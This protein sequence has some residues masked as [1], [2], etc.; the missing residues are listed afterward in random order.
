MPN[1]AE[2]NQCTGCTACAATCPTECIVMEADE[3]G[4]RHPVVDTAA[5]AACGLC[6]K[7]C[8]VVSPPAQC[9]NLP[10]AYA[11]Y[12]K[13]ETMRLQSSSGGL[14]TEIARIVLAEGGIVYGA[15]Y[16][17]AFRVVHIPVETES[18]LESLRGAK[19]SQSVLGDAF[20]KIKKTLESGHLVLFSGTPCQV[21]GLKA[22][23]RRDYEKLIT[24]DFICHS[25]PSPIA[26]QEF[27]RFRGRQDASGDMPTAIQLRSKI[28]GW[29]RYRYSNRFVY[30]NG[31]VKNIASGESLYM[32]LFGAN[33]IS[34]ESC[35]NC[36]FKGYSRCSDLTL[37]DFWGIWNI[38]PEMDD[39]KGTSVV[40]C[41][42]ERGRT[43]LDAIT[44]RIVLKQ[45]SLEEVSQENWS[46]LRSA[47]QNPNRQVALEY[48]R[49]G[50]I[51]DC[52]KWLQP[53]KP[54]FKQKLTRII[55]KV[56]RA[57][58]IEIRKIKLSARK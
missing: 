31:T 40:L 50:R 17:E 8:P 58:F 20:P 34:R 23:L 4:F 39:D 36:Q 47:P 14:F 15:A 51:D 48:I 29:S 22:Y 57:L 56:G 12:S 42:S 6:E 30:G 5:C 54:T 19:Y 26:W 55:R 33:L 32:K 21:S 18:A 43:M 37:G 38:A 46:I 13:E 49:N 45:V 27:I 7:S 44:D 53:P 11:A 52:T 28:S 24:M 10:T 9:L 3:N 16:D 41:Q 2:L 35:F 25:V 1:L